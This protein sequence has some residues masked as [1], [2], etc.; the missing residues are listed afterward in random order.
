MSKKSS[1]GLIALAL[2]VVAGAAALF[3]S[4]KENR[5]NVKKAVKSASV[6][7][8]ALKKEIQADPKKFARKVEQQGKKAVQKSVAAVKAKVEKVRK[9]R[10]K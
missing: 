4:K 3:F 1:G 2:G 10:R 8:K 6:K 5:E 7:A 9:T